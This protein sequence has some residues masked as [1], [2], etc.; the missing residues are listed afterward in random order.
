MKKSWLDRLP[1]KWRPF[2][3]R[4]GFALHPAYRR[5]GGRIDR[6]SQDMTL[7]RVRLPLNRNTRN[8]AGSIFG[9]SLFAVT[10]GPHPF[11]IMLRL[12]REYVVWDRAATIQYKRPS[13]IMDLY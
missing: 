7:I 1:E 3:V 12:G 2:V 11:L 5:T 10:D 13:R 6:M 8:L 9:G 4:L